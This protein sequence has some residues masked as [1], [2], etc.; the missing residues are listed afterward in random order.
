MI[1]HNAPPPFS[2]N[3]WLTVGLFGLLA[4]IFS[5]YVWSEKEV[6]RANSL[7]LQSFLLADE[8]RQSSDDLTR[9]VRS[10]VVTG[11][12]AYKRYYQTILDIRD[13]RQP[14]PER[15]ERIYWDLVFPTGT[16]PRPDSTQRIALLD[17]MRQAGFSAEEFNKLAEGKTNSDALSKLEFE[18]MALVETNPTKARTMLFDSAYYQAK[19]AIM[20]PIDDFYVLMDKRTLDVV[21]AAEWRASGVRVVAILFGIVVLFS[22][23]SNYRILRNTLGGTVDEVYAQ[24]ANIG[25]G[26]F[27]S[28]FPAA[29]VSV[30]RMGVAGGR[31]P[32]KNLFSPFLEGKW[33]VLPLQAHTPARIPAKNQQHHVLGWLLSMQEKLQ[34]SDHERKQ[35]EA[36]LRESNK[37]LSL[38]YKSGQQLSQSLHQQELAT[39]F[40]QLIAEILDY[41]SLFISSYDPQQQ[42]I[43]CVYALLDGKALD[44]SVFPLIPLEPEGRGTQSLVIR[45]GQPLLLNDFQTQ[46]QTSLTQHIVEEDGRIISPSELPEEKEDGIVKSA[47]IL[48][49]ILSD[50]VIGVMQIFSERL[51]AYLPADLKIATAVTAQ[52]TIANNNALLYADTQK[53]IAIRKQAEAALREER[54]LLAQRVE[55][56]TAKLSMANAELSR[57]AR[58]KDD[59]LANMSHELRTPLNAILAL[60]ETLQEEMHGPLSERQHRS[61]HTI[62]TSGKH[63]LSLINDVLDLAKMDADKLPLQPEM[64]LA[65]DV[66]Q[67][68]LAFVKEIANKKQQQLNFTITVPTAR[69]VADPRRLKQILI[70]LLSNAVKFTPAGGRIDLDINVNEEANTIAFA[71]QDTG[72]GIAQ[73]DM[74][75]LF[76]PFVQLESGLA[77]QHEG[78]G[79]GLTLVR[80]L[81]DL[82]GGSLKVESTPGQGSC[83][84]VNLPWQPVCAEHTLEQAL[85]GS[86]AAVS[87]VQQDPVVLLVDDNEINLETT[88]NY[89]AFRGYH[90]VVARNGEEAL[91]RAAEVHP[92]LII[93]DIQMPVL[94]GLEAIRRLRAQ[95]VFTQTPIIALTALAMNQDRERC[96]E[97]GANEYMSKPVSFKALLQVVSDLLSKS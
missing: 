43:R 41:S 27:S 46:V 85:L 56:R 61:L 51:N 89:L 74:S 9:M 8:L 95:S 7:R 77:R 65:I 82:H 15:Y 3:L 88:E 52:Y 36:A 17:L 83:F 39:L 80:R 79:L 64:I 42:M 58:I 13:G 22:L 10:Y 44:V 72:I 26:D 54:A 78:T 6:D 28:H 48:P 25:Q 30:Q 49:L 68:S 4:L 37:E 11:D 84:T 14:R 93:M 59:F 38:L 40:T 5:A 16:A 57:A 86:E 70:N 18:A 1:A 47:L 81:V 2:R 67:A 62:E 34:I 31:R 90:M 21:Q 53:E 45:S 23:W 20:K 76:L 19:A 63:L 69:L 32:P 12:P 94:D 92:A 29:K 97:A 87:A 75:Q 50:Q 55:D 73:A 96:L 60:S 33:R 91:A 66:G 71:V 24:I 35:A